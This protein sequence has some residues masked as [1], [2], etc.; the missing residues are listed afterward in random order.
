V[1]LSVYIADSVHHPETGR[2]TSAL[3]DRIM[4]QQLTW[5][6]GIGV[7]GPL[8]FDPRCTLPGGR[9]RAAME[10]FCRAATGERPDG[11]RWV[12]GGLS[13]ARHDQ[14]QQRDQGTV[15]EP[16]R[17]ALRAEPAKLRVLGALRVLRMLP[18]LRAAGASFTAEL[19][20]I[21]EVRGAGLDR[22]LDGPVRVRR[23]VE[24]LLSSADP[25]RVFREE[26]R[27]LDRESEVTHA[28][29]RA[30]ARHAGWR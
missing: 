24:L 17:Q 1:A 11:V 3:F 4:R 15:T 9:I 13:G 28:T 30:A 2:Q 6:P 27:R 25:Y 29:A 22:S 18:L 10:E 8:S 19:A 20:E 12:H 26:Q 14:G 23:E 7:G 5:F 16:L 21:C